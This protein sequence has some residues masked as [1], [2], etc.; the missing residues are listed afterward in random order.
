M[1]NIKKKK[2]YKNPSKK[3]D[4]RASSNRNRGIKSKEISKKKTTRQVWIPKSIIEGILSKS[5]KRN[6]KPT[7]IWILKSLL[8][9]SN[10]EK[11]VKLTF[12]LPKA[13]TSSS[14]KSILPFH[15]PKLQPLLSIHQI[16]SCIPSVAFPPSSCHP[17]RCALM[18]IL[19]SF[20][21]SNLTHF[22]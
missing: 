14:S 11:Q 12:K 16:V 3:E 8:K 6:E 13:S 10:V 21:S 7:A 15:V 18:L 17:S 5:S 20:P 9:E 2:Q 1:F 4:H 22:A 19:P